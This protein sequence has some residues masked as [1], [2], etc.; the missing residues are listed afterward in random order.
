[1]LE[2]IHNQTFLLPQV[3][4]AKSTIPVAHSWNQTIKRGALMHGKVLWARMPGHGQGHRYRYE[5]EYNTA[6]QAILKKL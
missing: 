1:M 3:L 6:T 5:Y 4:K 2:A